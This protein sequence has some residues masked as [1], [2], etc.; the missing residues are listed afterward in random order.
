MTM[1]NLAHELQEKR[2]LNP[3]LYVHLR[4]PNEPY[5]PDMLQSLATTA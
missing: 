1:L 2:T 3:Q 4:T 5:Q